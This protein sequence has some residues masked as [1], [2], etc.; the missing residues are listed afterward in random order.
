MIQIRDVIKKYDDFV[1]VAEVALAV[2]GGEVFG[3]IGPNGAAVFMSTH[4]LF[5]AQ[6]VCDRVGVIH[7][8][9]LIATGT[10]EDL[11]LQSGAK[12]ADLE[13]V[14]FRLTQEESM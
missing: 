6:E 7:Q 8:G 13:E 9:R 5:V 10:M 4:T 1:A 3:F 12:R 14:F 2:Y 11:Q